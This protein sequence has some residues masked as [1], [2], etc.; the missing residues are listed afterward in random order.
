MALFYFAKIWAGRKLE[1]NQYNTYGIFI[2]VYR[3]V[4]SK[5]LKHEV[6]ALADVSVSPS[7]SSGK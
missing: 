2:V 3:K 4:D 6:S 1:I 7:G 5:Y